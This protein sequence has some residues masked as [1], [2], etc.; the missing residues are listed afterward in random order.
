[1]GGGFQLGTGYRHYAHDVAEQKVCSPFL[2][3]VLKTVMFVFILGENKTENVQ[4]ATRPKRRQRAASA[5]VHSSHP[6]QGNL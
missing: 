3:I 2:I 5:I 4:T 6:A 1:M